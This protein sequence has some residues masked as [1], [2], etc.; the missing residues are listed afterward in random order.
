MSEPDEVVEQPA[1]TGV[2]SRPDAAADPRD[3]AGDRLRDRA[4]QEGPRDSAAESRRD[5]AAE[6]RGAAPVDRE[7]ALARA[8]V[9]LADGLVGDPDVQELLHRLAGHC[10]DLL[11]ATA[12]GILLA[13]DGGTLALL[14]AYPESSR[15]LDLLQLQVDQGPCVDCVRSGEPVRS[16]DLAADA[17]VWPDWAPTAL[18]AGIRTVYAT[19]LRAGD[20]VI[21]TLNLF[22]AEPSALAER[23]LLVAR[24]LADVATITILQQRRSD[25]AGLLNRQLQ[26]ALES[27]VRIE[28]AKG[29]IAHSLTVDV[30]VAFQILR[31]N[32]R[33]TNTRLSLLADYLISGRITAADLMPLP[34]RPAA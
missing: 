33:A 29:V 17:H 11:D 5:R 7:V 15:V 16:T 14:A 28:Q 9:E 13:D 25:Q 19:P 22:R 32:S 18:E 23:D 4:G 10:V 24:A 2:L 21:G 12:C 1:A 6:A 26:S 3:G 30:D 31:H 34:R 8:F 20:T 27:R